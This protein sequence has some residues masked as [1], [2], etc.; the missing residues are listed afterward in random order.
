MAPLATKWDVRWVAETGSTNADLVAAAQAGAAHGLV[1]VADH[2]VA[3]RG[4]LGRTWLAPPKASLLVSVLLRT[5]IGVEQAH[6]F[7]QAVGLAA[8]DACLDVAGVWPELKWPNDL[9]VGERKLAGILAEAVLDA[10]RIVAVVVGLGLNV[11]WPAALPEELADRATALNLERNGRSVDRA[12]L[13][14]VFLDKL[15]RTDLDAIAPRY[16]Q[17]L[18]TIGVDVRVETAAGQPFEGT[19]VDVTDDGALV[20]AGTDGVRH[21]VTAGDVLTLRRR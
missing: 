12:E 3:G 15:G 19:A 17:R 13:L 8:A 21:V 5:P 4:R 6:R 11:N 10:G 7:T 16:R 18:T 9:F 2:Q 20:V 1:L 14:E